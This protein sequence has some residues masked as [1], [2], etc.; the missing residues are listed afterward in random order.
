MRRADRRGRIAG[1]LRQASAGP[2]LAL[3]MLAALGPLLATAAVPADGWLDPLAGQWAG[4]GRFNGNDA[5]YRFAAEPALGGR[6]MRLQVRYTWRSASGAETSLHG[7]ALY[8]GQAA[9]PGAMTRGAWFDSEG[10]QY[11][12]SAYRDASGAVIVHWGEGISGRT[13]YRVNAA[14]ELEV[15]D[16][17]RRGSGDWQTFS[18]GRLARSGGG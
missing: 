5:E 6:F 17:F 1:P 13:E 9:A 8:P 14:G 4:R 7:E 12:T 11:A 10:H 2:G 3:A 15:T 16:S 18:Q